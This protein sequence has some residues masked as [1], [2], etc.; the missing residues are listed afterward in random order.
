[1][2]L[3]Q[4]LGLARARQAFLRPTYAR[5]YPELPP[6]VWIAARDVSQMIRYGVESQQRPWPSSGPRILADEH[7]RFRDGPTAVG[8]ALR[9]WRVG[10]RPRGRAGMGRGG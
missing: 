8:R 6:G 9:W 7:F 2:S 5:L 10:R 3:K 4:L 1:M